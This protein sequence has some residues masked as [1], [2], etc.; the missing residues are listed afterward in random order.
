MVDP[1]FNCSGLFLP[2]WM[3][4]PTPNESTISFPCHKDSYQPEWT[5]PNQQYESFYNI[6]SSSIQVLEST[7]VCRNEQRIAN[8]NQRFVRCVLG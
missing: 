3:A 2:A 6:V 8:T 1:G 7:H 5:G 4:E